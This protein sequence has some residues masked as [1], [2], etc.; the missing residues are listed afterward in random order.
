MPRTKEHNQQIKD[1][2]R[3]QILAAALQLFAT[4]GFAA[5]KIADISSETGISQGLIYHY[6]PSKDEIFNVLIS[7]ATEKMNEAAINLEQLPFT[8]KEKIIFAAESLLKGLDGNLNTANYYFL[9][10]QT[11]ISDSF[12]NEARHT[13]LEKNH[14]KYEVM[15]RIFK[16]GQDDGTV[17][18]F[19]VKEM[20]TLF[21]SAINGLALNKAIYRL[22]FT[23]PGKTIFLQMFLKEI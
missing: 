15:S 18:D 23:M 14:I 13:I 4:K 1:E 11:A 10:T 16:Q 21:F 7:S 9:I 3:E 22:N 2:R 8:A 20:T 6:F 12:P 5:T 17:K 19:D